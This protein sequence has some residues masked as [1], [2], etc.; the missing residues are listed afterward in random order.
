MSLTDPKYIRA[1][2]KS[3]QAKGGPL[4]PM[5]RSVCQACG[6]SGVGFWGGQGYDDCEGCRGSG[7]ADGIHAEHWLEEERI[8][9]V[10]I[11]RIELAK[12]DEQ[13]RV[14]NETLLSLPR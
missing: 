10:A 7:F 5:S 9:V 6:G 1:I 11:A 8:R 14:L 2:I 3:E 13:I 4:A 12:R